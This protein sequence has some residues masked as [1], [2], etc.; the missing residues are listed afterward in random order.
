MTTLHFP[1]ISS[2]QAGISL[3]GAPAV[4][5]KATQ[6]TAYTNPD[7]VPAKG[8]A[9]AAGA[10]QMAYHF[11]EHGNG[12]AQAAHCHAVA[13]S[14]PLMLDWE[15]DGASR[16]N[17]P[18][19]VA[20]IDHYRQLGGTCHL[21]YLPEWYWM[22]LGRPS[23]QPLIDRGML[24]VSS[25]YTTYSDTGPGWAAYGGLTPV[26]W[27]Y[28]D[29]AAFNGDSVDFNAY[30]GP[31]AE[32]KALAETGKKTTIPPPSGPKWPVG[33]TLRQGNTGDAVKALQTALNATNLPGVRNITVNGIFNVQT[34]TSVRNFQDLENL[35]VDGIAGKHTRDALIRIGALPA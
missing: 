21:L 8:R 9:A 13:G 14:V 28:T 34:E 17:V 23:L 32:L 25:H 35:A 15:E 10:Y 7:Y 27:Q 20:F 11:L 31:L 26:I 2:H 22:Q 19:A 18:D 12:A 6:G 16:P 29:S 1:D 33:V 30:R 5:V 24:A 3:K 4:I